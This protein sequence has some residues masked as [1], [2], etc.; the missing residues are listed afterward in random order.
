MNKEH[1]TLSE[2]KR[3]LRQA[4]KARTKLATKVATMRKLR[5][6]TFKTIDDIKRLH[7]EQAEVSSLLWTPP[8]TYD[9]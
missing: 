1:L 4:R 6:E 8:R 2:M 9:Y 7:Q 5:E 3:Q